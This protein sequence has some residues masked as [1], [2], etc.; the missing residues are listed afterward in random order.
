VALGLTYCRI[1]HNRSRGSKVGGYTHLQNMSRIIRTAF[2]LNCVCTR[3]KTQ[4][5]WC[6]AAPF[7]CAF[8]GLQ[9]FDARMMRVCLARVCPCQ[10]TTSAKP[11]T[12]C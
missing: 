6:A 11:L 7:Y 4:A 5:K 2:N 10:A 3:E 1:S 12:W 9:P 8:K